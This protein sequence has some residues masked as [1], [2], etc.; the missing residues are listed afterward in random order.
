MRERIT[1]YVHAAE[2]ESRGDSVG[3]DTDMATVT[4]E[5]AE[6]NNA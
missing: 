2:K 5:K 6:I 4:T 1:R 3:T